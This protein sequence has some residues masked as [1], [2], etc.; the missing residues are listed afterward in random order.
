[1]PAPHLHSAAGSLVF[2]AVRILKPI[3]YLF[4]FDDSPDHKGVAKFGLTTKARVGLFN[5]SATSGISTR[6]EV[7]ASLPITVI[8][9]HATQ[10]LNDAQQSVGA[11][12]RSPSGRVPMFCTKSVCYCKDIGCHFPGNVPGALKDLD[13]DLQPSG[14]LA[15]RR[16]SF[17]SLGFDFNEGTQAGV[18]R[19]GSG[20]E[21]VSPASGYRS[22]FYPRCSCPAQRKRVCGS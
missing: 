20:G 14:W 4:T 1:M 19:V 2:R 11:S 10:N 6:L 18:G 7:S 5:I 9:A 8:D 12:W 13:N 16:E 21:A 3:N 15:L 22:H 17:T